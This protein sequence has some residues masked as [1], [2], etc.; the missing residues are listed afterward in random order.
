MVGESNVNSV[1]IGNG[2]EVEMLGVGGTS[3][4]WVGGRGDSIICSPGKLH[5][6]NEKANMTV[7]VMHEKLFIYS[8]FVAG[9]LNP[10]TDSSQ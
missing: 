9:N 1:S 6:D 10:W 8:S 4:G 3:V 7:M 5:A 2:V